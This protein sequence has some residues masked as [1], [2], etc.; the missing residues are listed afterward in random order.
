MKTFKC[1]HCDFTAQGSSPSVL[2]RHAKE[3]H[4]RARRRKKKHV[5]PEISLVQQIGGLDPEA[6][7]ETALLVAA[8]ALFNSS[9]GTDPGADARVADAL[10]ARFGG[11]ADVV[12]G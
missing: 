10:R 12:E 8:I 1:K 5:E 6:D 11:I 9:T 4:P 2:I 7:A 3:A